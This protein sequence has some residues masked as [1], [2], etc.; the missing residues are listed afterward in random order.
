MRRIST[1]TGSSGGAL[2][3]GADERF[4]RRS[5][6]VDFSVDRA[7]SAA[8]TNAATMTI[9]STAETT[10]TT[11]P[12]AI[13]IT[14]TATT[15]STTAATKRLS[16]EGSS[17]SIPPLHHR[18]HSGPNSARRRDKTRASNHAISRSRWLLPLTTL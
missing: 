11:N 13:L 5:R 1:A 18:V 7:Q 17:E 15:N 10:P 6:L 8:T 16:V 14:R 4:T 3:A 12:T 2:T 9:Q